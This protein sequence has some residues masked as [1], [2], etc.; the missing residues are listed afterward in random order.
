MGGR[1]LWQCV[2]SRMV[3]E[4]TIPRPA[5]PAI[6][7]RPLPAAIKNIIANQLVELAAGTASGRASL[8]LRSGR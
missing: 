6:E 2:E 7:F 8:K 3:P 5:P 4:N 1:L